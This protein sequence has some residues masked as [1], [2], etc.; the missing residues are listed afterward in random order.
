MRQPAIKHIQDTERLEARI[1]DDLLIV[2][3]AAI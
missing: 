1:S 3:H 2:F